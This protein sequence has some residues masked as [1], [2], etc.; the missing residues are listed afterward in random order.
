[1][2]PADSRSKPDRSR[3]SARQELL[4]RGPRCADPLDHL[5]AVGY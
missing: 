4:H 5:T 2:Y 3:I 1:M